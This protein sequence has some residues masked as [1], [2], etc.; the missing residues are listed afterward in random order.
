[1]GLTSL[2]SGKAESQLLKEGDNIVW[3]LS[4]VDCNSNQD[5]EVRD[6]KL[7]IIGL[8]KNLPKWAT[9][10]EQTAVLIGNEAGVCCDR[11]NWS[12][13]KKPADVTAEDGDASEISVSGDYA[14]KMINGKLDRIPKASGMSTCIKKGREFLFALAQGVADIDGA[15]LIDL[16]IVNKTPFIANLKKVLWTDPVT[17]ETKVQYRF[18]EFKPIKDGV[19]P[20]LKKAELV[21]PEDLA[22]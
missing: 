19:V 8:K 9:P 11:L 3:M 13:W 17:H 14:V 10:T 20:E 5:V 16:A 22:S 2:K 4:Q 15:D 7:V 12:S 6:G 21:I 18:N 1:V